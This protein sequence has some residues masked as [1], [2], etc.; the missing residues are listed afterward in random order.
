MLR[1]WQKDLNVA[2]TCQHDAFDVART[3]GDG[4]PSDTVTDHGRCR[5]CQKW[6]SRTVWLSAPDSRD[7]VEYRQL[8]PREIERCELEAAR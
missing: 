1:S 7:S 2:A 8:T 6:L 3:I 4:S 5:S